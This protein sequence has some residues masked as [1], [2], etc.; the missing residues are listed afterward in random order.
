LCGGFWG[1]NATIGKIIITF[2]A[3]GLGITVIP[4]ETGTTGED[5]PEMLRAGFDVVLAFGDCDSVG[6]QRRLLDRKSLFIDGSR[7]DIA[8]F[9]RDLT[10][11]PE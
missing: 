8:G 7:I 2:G 5:P 11:L 4:V 10:D 6:S 9:K 3:V 1:L